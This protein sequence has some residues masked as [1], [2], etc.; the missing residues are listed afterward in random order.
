[1]VMVIDIVALVIL[2]A[3]IAWVVFYRGR[4][5]QKYQKTSPDIERYMAMIPGSETEPFKDLASSE[6][7]S[8][9]EKYKN[10]F[11]ECERSDFDAMQTHMDSSIK[12][13]N[14]ILQRLPNDAYVQRD[15]KV[16]VSNIESILRNHLEDVR[17]RC[18]FPALGL[19]PTYEFQRV[20]GMTAFND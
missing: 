6:L 2:L 19:D 10:S 4:K 17:T 13:L 20:T 12:N 16:A 1:M 3:S 8:F 15:T 7:D 14:E 18:S 5:V 9:F 11:R